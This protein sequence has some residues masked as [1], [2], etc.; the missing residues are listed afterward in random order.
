MEVKEILDELQALVQQMP[1]MSLQERKRTLHAVISRCNALRVTSPSSHANEKIC[2]L[3]TACKSLAKR[4]VKPTFNDS[5]YV[6]SALRAINSLRSRLCF[7][8]R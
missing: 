6:Q 1:E 8:M 5:F 3:E 2:D 7:G 4:R